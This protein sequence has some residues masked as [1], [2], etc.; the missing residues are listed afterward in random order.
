MREVEPQP[1]L[2]ILPVYLQILISLQLFMALIILKI[3]LKN[4]IIV[5]CFEHHLLLPGQILYL[6]T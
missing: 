3:N 4:F 5:L 6:V 2:V 1:G